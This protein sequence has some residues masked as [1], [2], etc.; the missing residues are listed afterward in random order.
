M[1]KITEF[2]FN[3]QTLTLSSITPQAIISPSGSIPKE[4]IAILGRL[5]VT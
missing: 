4:V 1:E 3:R 5:S 2:V